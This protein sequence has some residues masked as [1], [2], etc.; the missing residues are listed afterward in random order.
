MLLS[1]LFVL[2]QHLKRLHANRREA[3]LL[4]SHCRQLQKGEVL[5]QSLRELEGAFIEADHKSGAK[6]QNLQVG[7]AR[8]FLMSVSLCLQPRCDH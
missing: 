8:I 6:E 1:C 3:E 2:Q 4:V 5:S 7:K